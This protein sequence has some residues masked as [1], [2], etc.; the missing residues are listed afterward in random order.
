M[1]LGKM[2]VSFKTRARIGAR[3][4]IENLADSIAVT[5]PNGI[6]ATRVSRA[7]PMPSGKAHLFLVNKATTKL[8]KPIDA[9]QLMRCPITKNI[10]L[11]TPP[12]SSWSVAAT[13]FIKAIT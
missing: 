1:L 9:I 7:A 10:E 5:T 4:N 11:V 13:P 12:D 2:R 8:P 3:K 6:P